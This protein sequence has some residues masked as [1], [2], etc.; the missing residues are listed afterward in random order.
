MPVD[1]R[2]IRNLDLTV[3]ITVLL[4]VLFGLAMVYS[5]THAAQSDPYYSLKKQVIGVVLGFLGLALIVLIDYHA[6]ERLHLV[7]YIVNILMLL[8]VL[9][10]GRAVHGAKS[11][12]SLGPL[13][14]QPSEFAKVAVIVTLARHLTNKESLA[15]A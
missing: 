8:S 5:A 1:R 10:L 12:F 9:F 7:I 11:W 14:L 6:S 4:L 2:L 3:L 13:G 15:S